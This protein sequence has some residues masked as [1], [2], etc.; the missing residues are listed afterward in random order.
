MLSLGRIKRNEDN[1]GESARARAPQVNVGGRTH[2][3]TLHTC[4][5]VVATCAGAS[6]RLRVPGLSV[7]TTFIST[8]IIFKQSINEVSLHRILAGYT[9]SYSYK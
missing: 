5:L 7:K 2:T 4:G 8:N 6:L 9:H 1:S 3:H